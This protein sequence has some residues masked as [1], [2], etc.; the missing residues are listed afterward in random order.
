[1]DSRS[2]P[3]TRHAPLTDRILL[4]APAGP[5][6]S[7]VVSLVLGGLG[8]RLDLPVDRVDE[9]ALAATTMAGSVD[10]DRLELE[11]EVREDRV[12]VRVGP[13]EDDSSLDPGRRRIIERLV[14][15]LATIRH[16]GQEW[17]ELELRRGAG[18]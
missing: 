17:A 2:D 9:L 3:G 18:V 4:T 14:D 13:L 16:D 10:S 12:T 15:G 11:V 6:G 1:M 8:A 7:G 5:H